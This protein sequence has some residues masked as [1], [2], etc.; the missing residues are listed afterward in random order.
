MRRIAAALLL[1]AL[2]GYVAGSIDPPMAASSHR[3][4]RGQADPLGSPPSNIPPIANP[5]LYPDEPNKPMHWSVDDLR[6][7]HAARLA[8]QRANP[9]RP[10]QG[11]GGAL[12]PGTPTFQ[13]QRFRTHNIGTNFRAYYE[14]ERPANLTGVM[15]HYDDVEQHEGVSDFYVITGGSGRMVVDGTIENREYR[16]ASGNTGST[17]ILLP[18]EFAGQPIK[19]GRTYTVKPGDWLAIPPNDPH[20]QLP[21]PNEGL[22]YLLLKVYIGLYPGSISR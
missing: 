14:Q 6:K 19:N 22:S 17:S 21:T 18:G 11:G 13:G 5:P 8:F 4:Q 20:W 9:D 1:S 16:R 7:I 15:S 2:V 10:T 12:P 3:Q